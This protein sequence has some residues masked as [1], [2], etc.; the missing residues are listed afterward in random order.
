MS[1]V[2]VVRAQRGLTLIELVFVVAILA[3]LAGALVPRLGILRN[4]AADGSN[5]DQ[6]RAALDQSVLYNIEQ[7]KYPQGEDSLLDTTG[8]VY[9][10]LDPGLAAILTPTALSVN[11]AKSINTQLTFDSTGTITQAYLFD[12]LAAPS[13]TPDNDFST[14]NTVLIAGA[15]KVAKVTI[16]ATTTSATYPIY[17]S[18]Y[19]ADKLPAAGPFAPLDGS[20]LVALGD[21]SNTETNGKTAVGA[22]VLFTKDPTAYN[23]PLFLL[24]VYDTGTGASYFGSLSGASIPGV[25]GGTAAAT[26]GALSPDG[27]LVTQNLANYQTAK[28]R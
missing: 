13:G 16:P 22:P 17:L 10:K 8:I 12:G 7:G 19:G 23:R 1:N 4:L 24:K 25:K 26:A 14:L 11:A 28:A 5:A 2:R 6:A 27:N 15:S 20:Y 3:I 21:G 18:V 9:T